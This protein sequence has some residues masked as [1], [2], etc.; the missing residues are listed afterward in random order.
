MTLFSL[1]ASEISRLGVIGVCRFRRV[2]RFGHR[3]E[4]RAALIGRVHRLTRTAIPV[5]ISRIAVPAAIAIISI[6]VS[7]SGIA[8]VGGAVIPEP[9]AVA[10]PVI[11]VAIPIDVT[12]PIIP[13]TIAVPIVGARRRHAKAACL[14]GIPIGR[15]LHRLRRRRRYRRIG[16]GRI[17]IISAGAGNE[18]RIV[19]MKSIRIV[20]LC[21]RLWLIDRLVERP[22][23]LTLIR[24]LVVERIVVRGVVVGDIGIGS[25]IIDRRIVDVRIVDI[26]PVVVVNRRINRS[27]IIQIL[28]PR[29]RRARGG[30]GISVIVVS[31]LC[32]SDHRTED[33]IG[34]L[35]P[36]AS[37][38]IAL[39]NGYRPELVAA[40]PRDL[41]RIGAARIIVDGHTVVDTI[42]D[43]GGIVICIVY[44][45]RVMN[46]RGIVDDGGI[47]MFI[48]IIIVHVAARDILLRNE[49]P[50]VGRRV[51]AAVYCY[52]DADTRPQRRPAIIV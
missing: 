12:I 48:H 26:P 51:V 52:I 25:V 23:E 16:N 40:Y 20:R 2:L 46:N 39:T 28:D 10:I 4:R 37:G 27:D 1:K 50:I 45:R 42:V 18:P 13:V 19:G 41:S 21:S 9:V 7:S 14:S 44:D 5:A 29:G 49:T 22:V 24:G 15:S 30:T 47:L 11:S 17:S 38:C 6:G 36:I 31:L 35:T 34:T 33:S 8:I 3:P 32:S 43:D